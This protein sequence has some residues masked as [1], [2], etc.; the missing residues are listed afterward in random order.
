[1][2]PP[3][4]TPQPDGIFRIMHIISEFYSTGIDDHLWV[5]ALLV[6][7]VADIVLGVSRAWAVH[8]FSS[9][10]FRKG[11]VGHVAMVVIVAF[12]YPFLIYMG[13]ASAVDAFIF[14]MLVAYGASILANLSALG[15]HIPYLDKIIRQNIDKDK[16]VVEDTDFTDREGKHDTNE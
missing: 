3:T 7:V 4:G 10:K 16:F 9:S 13:L 2:T 12:S 11:L 5:F 15:V 8:S 6:I 1:M 14:A